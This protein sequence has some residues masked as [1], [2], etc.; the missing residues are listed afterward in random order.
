VRVP[1][2]LGILAETLLER[3]RS[4]DA[5]ETIEAALRLQLQTKEIWCLPELLRVKAQIMAARGEA[6][7]ARAMLATAR[8]NA[9]KIGA[10]SLELR[11]VND[12]A[13]MAIA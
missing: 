10:R 8:E 9:L 2:Y 5:D 1:G 11:I 6:D 12:M 13:Q 3:G 7:P 4:A